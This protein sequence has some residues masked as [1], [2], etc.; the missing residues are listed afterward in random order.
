MIG[1]TGRRP[2]RD[3]KAR[4]LSGDLVP[5]RNGG[6]SMRVLSNQ[7]RFWGVTESFERATDSEIPGS[8]LDHS[9]IPI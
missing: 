9:V 4:A 8:I 5:T 6:S 2:V 1:E 3:Q 7:T